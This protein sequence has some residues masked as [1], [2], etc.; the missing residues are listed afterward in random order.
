MS[1]LWIIR[2]YSKQYQRLQLLSILSDKSLPKVIIGWSTAVITAMIIQLLLLHSSLNTNSSHF[3]VI[4]SA[5]LVMWIFRLVPESVPAI[6]II[7][8]TFFLNINPQQIILSGF[9]SD[10]FF[11]TLSFLGIGSVVI[12]SRLF[13]R[14]A[15]YLIYYLPPKQTLLQK[16]LFGIGALMTPIISV[17]SARLTLMAPLLD[18]ILTSSRIDP[19]STSANA[20]AC[21]AF[22]GCI[23]LSTI[24]LTGK[25]SNSVL[26]SM[27]S[28][29]NT[30][31]FSWLNWLFAASFPGL[32]LIGLFFIIQLKFFKVQNS[33]NINKFRLKKEIRSLGSITIDECAALLGTATLLIG[34]LCSSW[35]HIPG[36]G[37]C[38]SVF[39]VLLF[40]GAMEYRELK[41]NI[42]WTFLFYM[43]AIIGIMRYIQTIGIDLWLG[44]HLLW[45]SDISN[46]SII[47]FI[48][49][50]YL[51]SWLCGLV[52]GTMTA[53]AL[54]LTVLLPITQKTGV[55]SWLVAFIILMAT[56]AWVFPYQSNYYLCFEELLNKKKNFLLKP[57]LRFNSLFAVLKLG[58]LIASIPFWR[59]LEIL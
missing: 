28:Q 50:I 36:I 43:G 4:F 48:S 32:L 59:W 40:T 53:P 19:R 37:I 9:V 52:L 51:I 1:Y 12:K 29:Q 42:N 54:L 11:L 24:F 17:Q 25:S 31:Q 16:T 45:I 47:L 15:L 56:E 38:L 6:F 3:I 14:L 21:A 34:L 13:Y 57:L 8:S 35:Q 23:L 10:S 2:M 33:L 58:I 30:G 20:L 39:F 5:A 18:D 55:S 27:L 22:N 26:Y 44:T 7:L 49:C 46:G 41:T